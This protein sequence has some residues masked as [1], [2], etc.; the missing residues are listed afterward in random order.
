MDQQ[1]QD[2]KKIGRMV[3]PIAIVERAMDE[4]YLDRRGY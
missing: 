1:L 3:G 2:D 4:I